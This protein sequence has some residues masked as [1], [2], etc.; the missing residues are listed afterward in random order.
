MEEML[1][2]KTLNLYIILGIAKALEDEYEY[3]ISCFYDEMEHSFIKGM[4]ESIN[5]SLKIFCKKTTN[6]FKIIQ[7]LKENGKRK[8]Q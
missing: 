8:I 7:D 6:I 3:A 1:N 4:I 5:K 2:C